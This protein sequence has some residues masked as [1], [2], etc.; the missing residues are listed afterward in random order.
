MADLP[1]GTTIGGKKIIHKGIANKHRH[2]A[3]D[4]DGLN[5][6]A[7]G[8]QGDG[9]GIDA[10]V[11]SGNTYADL[12]NEFLLT[13]NDTIPELILNN[14]PTQN[15]QAV[16]KLYLQNSIPENLRNGRFYGITSIGDQSSS[17]YNY[18]ILDRYNIRF[19][20]MECLINGS[21]Y[22]IPTTTIDIRDVDANFENKEFYCY[23][24]VNTGAASFLIQPDYEVNKD[25]KI[26]IGTLKS[27][28]TSL[29]TYSPINGIE[30]VG[31]GRYM[32][33]KT[34]K[35]YSIPVSNPSGKIDNSWIYGA[36]GETII[37]LNG[38]TEIYSGGTFTYSITNYNSFSEY[39]YLPSNEGLDIQII[40][41]TIEVLGPSIAPTEATT[42]L[43]LT[44][45]GSE[46]TFEITILP[47]PSVTISGP[48][49]INAGGSNYQ[50]TIGNYNP[51]YDYVITT[52]HGSV[53][54]ADNIITLITPSA[55]ENDVTATITVS[56]EG[57][58]DSIDVYMIA[59]GPF[60]VVGPDE[61]WQSGTFTYMI[62]PYVA[63]NT[64]TVSVDDPNI[65]VTNLN[66]GNLE[67]SV[68]ANDGPNSEYNVIL[69][70]TSEEGT[71]TKELTVLGDPEPYNI[72]LNGEF[73]ANLYQLI[74]SPRPAL[75]YIVNVTGTAYGTT[76][77][78]PLSSFSVAYINY[79]LSTGRFTNG[80]TLTLN[81]DNTT[82]LS[83][84]GIGGGYTRPDLFGDVPYEDGMPGGD[85]LY[86]ETPTH[87]N[88]TNSILRA[89]GGGGGGAIRVRT[90]IGDAGKGGTK[91]SITSGAGG[92]SG[93]S[94]GQSQ[95]VATPS[96]G[97]ITAI[98]ATPEQGTTPGQGG[99]SVNDEYRDDDPTMEYHGRF[100]G[101]GGDGGAPAAPGSSASGTSSVSSNYTG[102]GEAP[103]TESFTYSGG[104]IGTYTTI[105]YSG[106]LGVGGAP[107]VAIR[108]N[109][110]VL[111]FNE[112]NNTFTGAINI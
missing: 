11:L 37:T 106:R 48:T 35:E 90:N 24:E 86:I 66:N 109:G 3:S 36:R 59:Q 43:I 34:P 31:I 80:S 105:E 49:E 10:D 51:Y 63:E 41:D 50:Y 72:T 32:L 61:I 33:S 13:Q 91:S 52:T 67:V 68:P 60:E 14:H 96:T 7:T 29:S 111:S 53:T 38:P 56:R 62:D 94:W 71:S 19:R 4:I 81:I 1:N 55:L 5:T 82:L 93:A 57:S 8:S 77:S 17:T 79:S 102:S 104:G 95:T 85:A 27:N 12:S 20:E 42:T 30:R 108:G 75:N 26:Y 101:Y 18:E 44:K 107:G 69:S 58:S 39:D 112:S 47:D 6:L 76:A 9:G 22:I 88:I 98:D 28:A 45:D 73:G 110:M 40:D 54:R 16:S 15:N 83:I 89:G 23:I 100:Y 92:G 103:Y 25:N 97:N 78:V 64:Y 84:G 70:V 87:I 46:N 99:T 2:S 74:G 65:T 21:K